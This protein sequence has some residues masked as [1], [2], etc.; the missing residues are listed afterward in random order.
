MTSIRFEGLQ[1]M[2]P[3]AVRSLMETR[4][5]APFRR[6]ALDADIKN[7]VKKDVFSTIPWVRAELDAAGKGVAITLDARDETARAV[8]V[9]F[10]GAVAFDRE[11]LLPHV[12]TTA[13]RQVNDFTLQYD[14]SQLERFYRSQGHHFAQVD[15]QKV[16]EPSGEHLVRFLITEGPEVTIRR[17]RIRGNRSFEKDDLLAETEFIDEPGF[18]SSET[19]IL[20][21]VRRDLVAL[22]QFYRDRGFRDA[23]VTLVSWTPTPDFEEVDLR[24]RVEEGDPYT[25]RSLTLEGVTIFDPRELRAAMRTR[26]GGRYEP[27]AVLAADLRDIRR[28]Y[29]E[30]GYIE[31]EV[32][33]AST[34]DLEQPVVDVVV[35]VLESRL[36][37]VGEIIIEDNR[38]TRDHVIRRELELYTGDPLN[39]RKLRRAQQ[40]IRALRYWE[41]G[42]EGLSVT[43]AP[44]SLQGYQVFKDTYV[45]LRDTPRENVKDI[46]IRVKEVDT[47]SLRFAAGVGSN[48][49]F[50]G[51]I[52]YR[53]N[54]FDP[55]DFPED[56]GDVFDAFT[57]GGQF[58]VLSF[59]PGT[60]L[61]RWR[62]AWGNPR[63]FDSHYSVS[64][65]VYRTAWRREDWDEDRLGYSLRG[66]RRL[67]E[68]LVVGLILR[69]E[70]VDVTD[71]DND[72]PQLVF[73]FEGEN[74]VASLTLD[75]RLDRRDSFV[76]PTEGYLA[77]LQ[78]E[79]AG[80]WGDIEFDKVTLDGEHFFPLLEDEEERIHV[81]KVAGALG[82]AS[83]RGS[84]REVPV[85]ERFFL[86]GA[87]SLRGFRF[88]GVGPRDNGDPIGGKAVWNA[89]AQYS[90]PLIGD[91]VRGV[92]FVDTGSVAPDWGSEEILDLRA[93]AGVGVRLSIPFLGQAPVAI[94]FG[95]PLLR[96][97]GDEGQ[98]IS[99]S[100]G[101][102]GR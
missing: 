90:F 81:L 52:T 79:H 35:R 38:E 48:T 24:I 50:L 66:G 5:G 88:R 63:V 53:K 97:S 74:R 76:D 26:V 14:A 93:G 34:V 1:R 77:G 91:Q 45:S 3:A 68:D 62:V 11:D 99:F 4:V 60:V 12:R 29:E 101:A 57:G 100:F 27:G 87:G 23:R 36:T 32:L 41:Q 70:L 39:L 56:V 82:W 37:R 54:N 84:T 83:E 92:A 75:V 40:R 22:E 86:G 78:Y 49:G 47:G 89:T 10:H 69:D 102:G 73:D 9:V 13:G 2:E 8:G 94:D 51:D 6:K 59:Q 96:Q 80:L 19:F 72:A 58:L 15:V 43:H 30:S 42:P 98:I 64:A 28:R 20:A 25:V 85:Y 33:D 7:L 67:G 17:V 61:T 44:M 71:I 16:R 46:V 55:F 95:V 31:T 21:Q 18:L 65:E